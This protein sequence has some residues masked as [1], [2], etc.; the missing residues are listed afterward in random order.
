M[1]DARHLLADSTLD[2][3]EIAY[4]VGFE[5]RNYFTLQFRKATGC[6]PRAYRQNVKNAPP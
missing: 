1:E 6:S 3:A 4:A 5:D 2:I